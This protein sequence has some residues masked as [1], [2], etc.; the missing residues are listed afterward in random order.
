MFVNRVDQRL[1]DALAAS[2]M[3]GEEVRQ[4][5]GGADLNRAS[6]IEKVSEAHYAAR[7]GRQQCVHGLVRIE[8]SRPGRLGNFRRQ[9]A[10]PRPAIESV[11]A[12]P[13]FLPGRK[14]I[15]ANG[16]HLNQFLHSESSYKLVVIDRLICLMRASLRL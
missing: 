11:V 16:T 6:M 12:V 2:V 9:G 7:R 13:K 14:V 1:A 8:E 15:A 3:V 10:I 5:A 4:V